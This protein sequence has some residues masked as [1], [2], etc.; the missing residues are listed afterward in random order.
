MKLNILSSDGNL[1]RLECTDDLTMLEVTGDEPMERLLGSGCYARTVLLSLARAS[2]IDSAGIGWLVMCHKHFLDGGGRL[3]LHS[4]AP[5][6]NHAFEIL[7]LSAMLAVAAD[8]AAAGVL[9]RG[10]TQG[11]ILAP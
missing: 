8:E 4:L 10:E 3:V 6:V 11:G 2:Y 5:M 7:G 9:A 1:A